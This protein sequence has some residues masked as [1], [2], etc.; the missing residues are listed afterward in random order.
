MNKKIFVCG[1][2][3]LLCLSVWGCA[4]TEA[5]EDVENVENRTETEASEELVEESTN[6]MESNERFG[7][8]EN[9]V[10]KINAKTWEEGERIINKID[11]YALA[12]VNENDGWKILYDG[13]HYDS[14]PD[15]RFIIIGKGMDDAEDVVIVVANEKC[16]VKKPQFDGAKPN[17]YVM[18][19]TK[20]EDINIPIRI[21]HPDGTINCFTV[22]VN[23]E[24]KYS[25]EEET[26]DESQL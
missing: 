21:I 12:V 17:P 8:I 19:N 16:E 20:G 23:K 3:M 22:Y 1:V 4:E 6:L 7:K 18:I 24:W 14:L 25:W 9:G 2:I 26:D 15:E 13:A 10:Q 11:E 5:K